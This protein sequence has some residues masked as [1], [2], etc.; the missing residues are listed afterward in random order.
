M[1][2][3]CDALPCSGQCANLPQPSCCTSI[4]NGSPL[5]AQLPIYVEAGQRFNSSSYPS[6]DACSVLSL[7]VGPC[8]AALHGGMGNHP[9][10]SHQLYNAARKPTLVVA[11]VGIRL[12]A[13]ACMSPC[14]PSWPAIQRQQLFTCNPSGTSAPVPTM[15]IL[16]SRAGSFPVL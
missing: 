9:G 16:L 1:A 5:V 6:L 11:G 2:T 3:R 8:L 7:P 10:A 15:P 12:M 14:K 13:T 4:L